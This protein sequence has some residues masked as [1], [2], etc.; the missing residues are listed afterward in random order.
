MQDDAD[1]DEEKEE[2]EE[3]PKKFVIEN[4]ELNF[5]HEQKKESKNKKL[6]QN[7]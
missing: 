6:M 7:A 5:L 1:K 4:Y 3:I 2:E